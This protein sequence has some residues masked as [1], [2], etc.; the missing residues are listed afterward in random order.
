MVRTPSRHTLL[1]DGGPTPAGALDALGAAL[2][3]WDRGIDVMVLTHADI[4]HSGGLADVAARHDIGFA[5]EP[6][7][8]SGD[9]DYAAWKAALE[10]SGTPVSL[11]FAGQRITLGG[12]TVEVLHPPPRPL[13]G[14]GS[15]GNNN[16]LVLRVV[17][18]DVSFLLTGDIESL[19]E[20]FLLDEGVGVEST[21]LKAA[22]HGSATSSTAAFVERVGPAAAVISVGADNRLGHPAPEVVS[23][24]QG[25][26]GD[27]LF[28]TADDGPIR[29]RTDGVRLWVERD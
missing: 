24:L 6:V 18:G 17:Y 16:S 10:R 21:V 29:F 28:I 9:V 4:D 11:A 25:A 26:V 1:I 8:P 27:A 7:G 5:L 23:T 2:P 15:D 12:T 13:L 19:A 22:H 14:T 20:R 3:F